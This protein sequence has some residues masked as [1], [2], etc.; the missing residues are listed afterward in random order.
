MKAA[1]SIEP[2]IWLCG[3]MVLASIAGDFLRCHRLESTQRQKAE[4]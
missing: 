4:P 1:R 2:V 3:L